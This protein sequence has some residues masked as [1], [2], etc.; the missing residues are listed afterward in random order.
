MKKLGT[1]RLG[2]RLVDVFTDPRSYSGSFDMLPGKNRHGRLLVGLAGTLEDAWSVLTHE[3]IEALLTDMA[4]RF[5]PAPQ[6]SA[7]ADGYVFHFDHKA[8]SEL[9]PRLGI[10]QCRAAGDLRRAWERA[11]KRKGRR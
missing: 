9:A 2:Y 8:L 11:Q 1:Y 6:F 10:F 7:S 3:A 5:V 4:L